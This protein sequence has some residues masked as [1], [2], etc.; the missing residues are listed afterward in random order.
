MDETIGLVV[1]LLALAVV[2]VV[3]SVSAH[4]RRRRSLLLLAYSAGHNWQY[5]EEKECLRSAFIILGERWRLE[6]GAQAEQ[7][8]SESGSPNVVLYTRWKSHQTG[9]LAPILRF[10]TV[11]IATNMPLSAAIPLLSALVFS[12][13]ESSLAPL[14]LKAPLDRRFVLLA[15]PDAKPDVLGDRAEGLLAAW[16]D[17]W[18]LHGKTDREG[19]SLYIPGKRLDNPRDLDVIIDLGQALLE[20]LTPTVDIR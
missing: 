18:E 7:S 14:P 3:F 19:I 4:H 11:P 20:H 10:G 8:S 5:Q 17:G 6:A 1:I 9:Q 16:P 15:Q 12:N 13:E 2:A